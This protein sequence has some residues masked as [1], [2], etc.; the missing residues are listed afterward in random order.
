MGASMFKKILVLA[1]VI[2]F[3]VAHALSI[4]N[5][6]S[7]GNDDD[8]QKN[9][10]TAQITLSLEISPSN[11]ETNLIYGALLTAVGDSAVEIGMNYYLVE[12]V[13]SFGNPLQKSQLKFT[14]GPEGKELYGHFDGKMSLGTV[15]GDGNYFGTADVSMAP[16][17]AGPHSYVAQTIEWAFY[18]K[19]GNITRSSITLR[20][21]PLFAAAFIKPHENKRHPD[22]LLRLIRSTYIPSEGLQASF[23]SK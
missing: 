6:Y 23:P 17:S 15:E 22:W 16:E 13:S 3:N 19:D 7:R 8:R 10:E 18:R 9:Y 14:P 12:R 20:P 21:S 5:T 4:S 1:S 2:T 11:W